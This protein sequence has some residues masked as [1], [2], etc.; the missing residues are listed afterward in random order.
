MKCV[1][2]LLMLAFVGF[3]H[4]QTRPGGL[5]PRNI[6]PTCTKPLLDPS[7]PAVFLTFVRQ[8]KIKPIDVSDDPN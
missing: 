6:G 7:K 3:S 8:E 1:A 5:R 4:G 2:L